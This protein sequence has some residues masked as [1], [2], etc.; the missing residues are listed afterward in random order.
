MAGLVAEEVKRR[1]REATDI[2]DLVRLYGIEL[3]RAGRNLKALCPFHQEKTASFNV[4]AEGQYFKCFGCGKSGDVFTFVMLHERVEFP[5]ALR[6]LAERAGIQVEYDPV[7]AGQAKKE[8]DWKS[9][10]YKLNTSAAAYYREML[11]GPAGA[12]ARAY[13]EKR[14]LKQEMWERFGLGYAPSGGLAA[15]LQAQ[16][17]PPRALDRAGLASLREDGSAYDYFRDRLMFPI[18][19]VQGRVIGF[20]GRVLGDG[21][22]KYLNTR[23]TP[24]FSKGRT[25][26]GLHQ[27][28]EAIVQTRRAVLMEGYTDVIMSHQFGQR[29][30]VAALGTAITADHVRMLRRVADEMAVLTDS[31]AAGARAAERSVEVLFQE[32]EDEETRIVRLPGEAKDPCDFLL[33]RGVE[34][35]VAAVQQGQTLFEYKF[36]RVVAEHDIGTPGGQAAAAKE[37][38]A[39]V[40]LSPD[41]Q[42]RKAYRRAVAER[43]NLPEDALAFTPRKA[44]AAATPPMESV[45]A[46]SA[47]ARAERDLLQLLFHQPAFIEAAA[48]DVDL[49]AFRGM[50]ER[51]IG[52]AVLA[53]VDAGR[54]PP[55]LKNLSPDTHS[56]S[57]MVAKE[58][59]TGL[60]SEAD[61]FEG[62]KLVKEEDLARARSLCVNL[63][64]ESM[65]PRKQSL[66]E[67]YLG[68]LRSL[69]RVRLE[70]E[71]REAKR[72]VAA[73]RARGDAAAEAEAQRRLDEIRMAFRSQPDLPGRAR[74]VLLHGLGGQG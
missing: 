54:L 5:D 34:P 39:L 32:G 30:A 2:V 59:L 18:S 10:L 44:A 67:H 14:G 11:Y 31:D 50:P 27:A 52:K 16:K 38:M 37:L 17:A 1:V 3:K 4:N 26:Y 48:G 23:E 29:N 49:T 61:L 64:E 41:P 56:L 19:D 51:L 62:G 47:L 35:F 45:A 6:L 40:S 24:L 69:Q 21:E 58:V 74:H 33:E 9:Y 28:R 13:L 42:R 36:Q 8:G 55:D 72:G 73:A 57:G 66:Q 25:I 70:E 7:A 63:A 65:E 43:L 15:R 12:A 68:V 20:G 53:A 46:E 60:S 22:P 71:L